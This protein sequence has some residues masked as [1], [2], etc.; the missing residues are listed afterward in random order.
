M[1]TRKPK[2]VPS[3]AEPTAIE[4]D[5]LYSVEL[6]GVATY[7]GTPLSPMHNP[8][9]MKGKVLDGIRDKVGAFRAA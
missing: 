8:H 9:L 4:P 7:L 6:N 2:A 3:P 1:A 5:A